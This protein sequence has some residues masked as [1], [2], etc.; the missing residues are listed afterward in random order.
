MSPPSGQGDCLRQLIPVQPGTKGRKIRVESNHL[1]LN[2]GKILQAVHYD[3]TITPDT[4]KALLRDVMNLFRDKHY[5][6]RYPAFDGR[7][8]LYT[9]TK[10][11]FGDTISDKIK[12]E[13]ENRTKEFMVRMLLI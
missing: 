7:K 4:P 13:G 8:N 9:P 2:L 12:I 11:P 5:K 3:V 1:A 6:G 10:L